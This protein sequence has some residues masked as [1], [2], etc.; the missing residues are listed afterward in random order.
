METQEPLEPALLEPQ[1][2]PDTLDT[3]RSPQGRPDDE[4]T[5]GD[6]GTDPLRKQLSDKDKHIVS[7]E[8]ELRELKGSKK[9][10]AVASEDDTLW[11]IEN[12]GTLKLVKDEYQRYLTLGYQ[13]EHAL[14]LAKEDR[15]I[16]AKQP[17]AQ[18]QA[19]NSGPA[20]FTNR[21]TSEEGPEPTPEQRARGITKEMLRRYKA[22][23]EA[24][25]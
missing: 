15:G 25:G 8:R 12:A 13:K 4:D 20:T 6:A 24:L 1:G 9:P 11:L 3:D 10:K 14:R 18:T 21:D 22:E 17:D 23:V 7:L 19:A 2:D 5:Q 16:V